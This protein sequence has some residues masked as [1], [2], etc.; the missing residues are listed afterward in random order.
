MGTLRATETAHRRAT[1]LI[2]A[3]RVYFGV[4]GGVDEFVKVL[5]EF[6][7]RATCV[8]ESEGP[9]VERVIL[10]VVSIDGAAILSFRGPLSFDLHAETSR[11]HDNLA[12]LSS[13]DTKSRLTLHPLASL[14]PSIR[15]VTLH[16]RYD[17][18]SCPSSVLLGKEISFVG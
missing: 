9:G 10:E 18:F 14:H 13:Y 4:G 1:A 5:S 7:G 2:A 12:N 16:V 3:K 8:W 15:R 11:S 17:P 6:G